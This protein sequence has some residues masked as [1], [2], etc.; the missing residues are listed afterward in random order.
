MTVEPIPLEQIVKWLGARTAGPVTSLWVQSVVTD[1]RKVS[2]GALF[3]ALKGERAD[4][5]EFVGEAFQRGAVAAV[6]GQAV[7]PPI[8]QLI[9]PDTLQALGDLGNQYL[10]RW[11]RLRSRGRD[12]TVVAVTGS[13]GKT[14][15]KTL[16][17]SVLSV[18]GPVVWAP[19]SYNNEV[20]V[21]LTLFQAT[22]DHWAVVLEFATRK[23][24]DIAYLRQIAPPDIA[25]ITN[26]G[27]A[28][29]GLLKSLEQIAEEKGDILWLP[30][31]VSGMPAKGPLAVLPADDPFRDRLKE[32]ATGPVVTFGFSETADVRCLE[33]TTSRE[34]TTFRADVMGQVVEVHLKGYGRH[35]ALN[36][37]CALAVG[38]CLN[39]PLD[40]AVPALERTEFPDM[41][42]QLIR[43]EPPG[44]WIFN[45]AYNANP[46]AVSAALETLKEVPAHR[47]VAVL[48]EMKE[49]GEFHEASHREVGRL[50]GQIVD[51]LIVVGREASGIVEGA[52]SIGM[53]PTKVI[54]Y[55]S[56]DCAVENWKDH[57]RP[58]DLVL[59]K[60]SRAVAMERLLG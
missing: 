19:A 23:V 52:L 43:L 16:I 30:P 58:D 42:M 3:V 40:D 17:A 48:G 8:P 34:G 56:L 5:H 47:R 49:L 21:P 18:A 57:L 46:D 54:L 33:W 51:L 44:C 26:I 39:V 41:R 9:V 37:I 22:K 59:V 7:S 32:K 31:V 38:H 55:E 50:A 35:N 53:E 2:P 15:T 25:V 36:A 6:V 4:G 20:G 14:T 13:S 45:D 28:H 24:G 29:I 27:R 11:R 12:R 10:Q 60:G 1:S